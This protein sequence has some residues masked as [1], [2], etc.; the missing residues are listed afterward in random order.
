MILILFYFI[1]FRKFQTLKK[2][3]QQSS[4]VLKIFLGG[5]L[6]MSLTNRLGKRIDLWAN[7]DHD[8]DLQ[9]VVYSKRSKVDQ[10]TTCEYNCDGEHD[11]DRSPV[12]THAKQIPFAEF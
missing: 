2:P 4:E 10:T 8:H 11:S 5:I 6:S 3:P 9:F 12:K 1:T 7:G